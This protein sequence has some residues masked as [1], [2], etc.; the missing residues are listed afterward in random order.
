MAIKDKLIKFLRY[1]KLSQREESQVTVMDQIKKFT[2]KS[3][4]GFLTVIVY[5]MGARLGIFD[6]LF[7]K[8]KVAGESGEVEAVSFTLDELAHEMNLDRKY[9]EAWL[10]MGLDR[11]LFE[12][13]NVEKRTLRTASYVYDLLINRESML[14]IGG[15]LSTF[16]LMA[17][18]QN[19][20]LENFKSGQKLAFLDLPPQDYQMAQSAC[21]IASRLIEEI[22]SSSFKEHRRILQKGG[23]IL[24]VGCGYGHTLEL[25]AKNYENA[26]IVGI[27]IDPNGVAHSLEIVKKNNW[28]DRI[29]VLHTSI[30]TYASSHHKGFDLM[31]M[32]HVLHEMD[33]DDSY[34]KEVFADLYSM[35]KDDGLLIVV[36]HNIP[37]MFAP[38]ER[39]LF[40]E[41]WH[42]LFEVG[43]NARFYTKEEFQEFVADTPFETAEF[44][45]DDNSYLWVLKRK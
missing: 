39:P 8:G 5:G 22:Y 24:E 21:A 4:Y 18:Y 16:Y 43:V 20:I 15:N 6:Y 36:E 11:G 33:P 34:R 29:E 35:L 13:D 38:K 40:F 9:L 12:I 10:H 28:Q 25:W 2:I 30:N 19:E 17:P 3:L 37:D 41:I 44:L 32:N 14:Y 31:L 45:E 1:A 7:A 42:K 23:S 26:R 27:D